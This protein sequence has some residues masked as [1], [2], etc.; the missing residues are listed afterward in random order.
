MKIYKRRCSRTYK[1]YA[2]EWNNNKNAPI[3][4]DSIKT[5]YDKIVG[6]NAEPT[7]KQRNNTNKKL[8]ELKKQCEQLIDKAQLMKVVSP[9]KLH[10]TCNFRMQKW[11]ILMKRGNNK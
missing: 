9:I 11:T 4:F 8:V 1:R 2:Q 3:Q 5:E 7:K 10:I 6:T